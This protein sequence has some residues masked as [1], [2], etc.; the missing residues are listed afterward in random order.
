MTGMVEITERAAAQIRRMMGEQ[1][2][3]GAA[4]RLGVKPSGCSGF[5]YVMEFSREPRAGDESCLVSGLEVLV[6]AASAPYLKGIVL[7]WGGEGLLGTGFKFS[8]PNADKTCGCG[9][10]FAV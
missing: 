3:S 8:N 5:E 1:G 2:L 6:D 7:D 4:L 10:S 9:K